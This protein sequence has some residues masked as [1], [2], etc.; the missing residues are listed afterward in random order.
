MNDVRTLLAAIALFA[1]STT[2]GPII[3]EA[4]AGLKSDRVYVHPASEIK[5]SS[6]D[7]SRIEQA[8]QE[9][10]DP[11]FVAVLPI[12]V[13]A[14]VG[15]RD[16]VTRALREATGFS[17]TYAV[18]TSGGVR[19]NSDFIQAGQIMTKVFDDHRGDG[20]AA[21]LLAFVEE[22]QGAGGG[23]GSGSGESGSGSGDSR[24]SSGGGLLPWLLVGGAVGGGV[25]LM[26]KSNRRRQQ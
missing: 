9:G 5:L 8:I 16:A 14:E 3:D 25:Y 24:E 2:A 10:D 17:G 26:R 11:I 1:G 21:V 20:A 12:A 13:E 15:G 6:G 4:A 19:A 22:V 18:V 7:E 23:S